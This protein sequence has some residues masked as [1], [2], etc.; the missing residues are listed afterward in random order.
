MEKQKLNLTEEKA[1][2]LVVAGT[3][4]AVLLAAILVML[5][6]YQVSS[7]ISYKA[8]ID[9]YNEQIAYYEQLIEKGESE[10][11]TFM[12]RKW[13]EREAR[14]LGLVYEDDIPMN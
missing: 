12:L 4:G 1:K 7:M 10:K 8:R 6:I 9:H 2:K 3:V 14:S 5:L 13:I 11:E